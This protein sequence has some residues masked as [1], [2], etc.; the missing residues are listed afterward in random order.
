MTAMLDRDLAAA[1]QP[2]GPSSTSK[3][4]HDA[5]GV[6][7]LAT[8]GA[9]LREYCGLAFGEHNHADLRRA[10]ARGAALFSGGD[11]LRFAVMAVDGQNG[12][13]AIEWLVRELTIG[14]TYFFRLRE[15]FTALRRALPALLAQKRGAPTNQIRAWSAGCASGEEAYSLAIS[16]NECLPAAEPWQVSVLA[17]DVNEDFLARAATGEYSAWSLRGLSEVESERYFTQMA[18]NRFRLKDEYRRGVQLAR[19][20]LTDEHWWKELRIDPVFD[21][22]L[23]R[24]VLIYFESAQAARIAER[25]TDRLS[26]GGYLLFGPS[27]PVPLSLPGLELVESEGAQ[28]FHRR[29]A[30][31]AP[32]PVPVGVQGRPRT[33]RKR[34]ATGRSST[35]VSATRRGRGPTPRMPTAPAAARAK[36]VTQPPGVPAVRGVAKQR[37]GALACLDRGDLEGASHHVALWL[38]HQPESPEAHYLSATVLRRCGDLHR[39]MM[40]L[41]QCTYFDP[42]FVLAHFAMAELHEKA[43]HKAAADGCLKNASQLLDVLD[44]SKI[45]VGSD[46]IS[47]GWLRRVIRGRMKRRQGPSQ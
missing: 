1:G 20:N 46:E 39:A 26:A 27:D 23:C 4:P 24:N 40:E 30:A 44:E 19:A 42:N 12:G 45:L 33:D 15:Q 29:R 43:G 36:Q 13:K 32:V 11:Q 5:A 8:I 16:L 25:L 22:I 31:T 14:E 28:L 18:G 41:R 10:V 47:A 37:G 38:G 6:A 2:S 7:M 34:Q 3:S 21:I 9:R 17:T 35:L